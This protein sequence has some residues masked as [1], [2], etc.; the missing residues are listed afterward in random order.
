MRGGGGAPLLVHLLLLSLATAAHAIV[1][2]ANRAPQYRG[3]AN[4][5][6]KIPIQA[7]IEEIPEKAFEQIPP[8]QM[9]EAWRRDEKAKELASTLKGCSLYLVGFS[10][11]KAAAVGR[12]LT[13]RLPR[14]RHFDVNE[15]VC[16]TYKT[17][18]KADHSIELQEL[19]RAETMNDVAQLSR[20]I[21]DQVQQ[22]TRGVISVWE[23]ATSSSDFAVMQQGIVVHLQGQLDSRSLDHELIEEWEK[24]HQKADITVNLDSEMPSDDVVLMI[25]NDLLDF[26][27]ANP[28]RSEQWK[29]KADEKLSENT[30]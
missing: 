7:S 12:I 8:K 17:L 18:S 29:K 21:I 14:Y 22:Y 10:S 28:A 24:A 19:Y 3:I 13:K 20:A 5:K 23:G 25:V 4:S 2:H 30:D 1:A 15:I 16:S 9:A 11:N 27:K 26:I 6:Q